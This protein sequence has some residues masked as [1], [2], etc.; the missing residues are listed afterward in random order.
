[1]LARESFAAKR[2]LFLV[3]VCKQTNKM[4][5]IQFAIMTDLVVAARF[6][7][8]DTGLPICDLNAF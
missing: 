7:M 5:F 4:R 2:R 1:M 8:T 3:V 6:L